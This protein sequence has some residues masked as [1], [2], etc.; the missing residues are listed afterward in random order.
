ML[1]EII[2]VSAFVVAWLICGFAPWLVNSVASRGQAGLGNLPIC[3]FS[4]VVAGMAVPVLG[5]NGVLGIWL[6]LVAAVIVPSLLLAFRHIVVQRPAP[7]PTPTPTQ[8]QQT[9]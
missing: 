1:F 4:A 6:S 7:A 9:K 8:E 2:F 3:L 5:A